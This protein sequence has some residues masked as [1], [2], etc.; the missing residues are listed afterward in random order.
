MTPILSVL[1]LTREY[2]L[3]KDLKLSKEAVFFILPLAKNP[4]AH[5]TKFVVGG[6][7]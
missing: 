7:S 3:T 1:K 4:H 2:S 6:R 5:I